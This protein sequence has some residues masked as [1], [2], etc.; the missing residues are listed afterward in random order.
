M[1][2]LPDDFDADAIPG[3]LAEG[4]DFDVETAAYPEAR[5]TVPI[6]ESEFKEFLKGLPN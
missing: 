3:L 6:A 4:W 1:E 2:A 5:H